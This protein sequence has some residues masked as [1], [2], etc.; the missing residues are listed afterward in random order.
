MTSDRDPMMDIPSA[1]AMW[2]SR[3]Q[4]PDCERYRA[5]FEEW[6]GDRPEHRAAYNK[7]AA[8]FHD[9]RLLS[10]SDRWKSVVRPPA[11]GLRVAYQAVWSILLVLLAGGL[12]WLVLPAVGLRLEE[13]QNYPLSGTVPQSAMIESRQGRIASE[14]LADGSTA[15]IDTGGKLRTTFVEDSRDIWLERGR[16]RFSVV[17]DGRP[18]VVH[19]AGGSVTATGTLFDVA[20]GADGSVRVTLLEGGVDVRPEATDPSRVRSLK[21]GQMLRFSAIDSSLKVANAG[22]QD[23]AWPQGIAEFDAAPLAEVIEQANRY[24]NLPIHLGEE[25]LGLTKVSGRFRINEAD[26]L[27]GNLA[28]MLDLQV[29]R[30]SDAIV[31]RQ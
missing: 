8:R 12:V 3:M 2:L 13:K 29:E 10:G 21:P 22:R 6:L 9:A 1:A 14:R 28:H 11:M 25:K 4:R 31:L 7:A 16:A 20:V 15:T 26:R 17:H 30:T 23:S 24:A 18:F 5:Q 27:A 19:A